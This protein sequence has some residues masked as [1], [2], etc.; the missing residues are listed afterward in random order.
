MAKIKE[1]IKSVYEGQKDF[2]IKYI[3]TFISIGII[4]LFNIFADFSKDHSLFY[5]IMIFMTVSCFTIES[6]FE[7]VWRKATLYIMSFILSIITGNFISSNISNTRIVLIIV[8]LY[9]A[10]FIISIYRIIENSE[11]TLSQFLSRF[12]RNMLIVSLI[13]V[14]LEIGLNLVLTI[15]VFLIFKPDNYDIFLRLQLIVLGLF[16]M[17][18][19][20]LSLLNVKEGMLKLL[21]IIICYVVL[22]IILIAE[23]VVYI[24]MFKIIVTCEIPKNQIFAIVTGMFIVAFPVWIMIQSFTEGNKYVKYCTKILPYSFIPL[25]ILQFYALAL[26]IGGNG[27]TPQRYFGVMLIVFEIVSIVLTLIKEQKYLKEVLLVVVGLIAISMI[28]PK[29]NAIE[30]SVANQVSRIKENYKENVEFDSLKEQQKDAVVSAYNFLKYHDYGKD[31]IPEY[32]DNEAIKKY[33]VDKNQY[34]EYYEE[35]FENY[36][37]YPQEEEEHNI[38]GY[39]T[40]KDICIFKYYNNETNQEIVGEGYN[41]EKNQE[42]DRIIEKLKDTFDKMITEKSI[43]QSFVEIDENTGIII[44]QCSIEHKDGLIRYIGLSGYLLKK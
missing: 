35:G 15:A 13:N 4:T 33:N 32:V 6:L 44:K 34:Q 10:L 3:G 8:G 40:I 28:M 21:K 29:T 11:L 17:P 5:F 26:R 22:P 30:F 27:V 7:D 43:E 18:A 42:E 31:K 38:E 1:S 39:K 20:I 36:Y 25:V 9:V 16:Y 12:F 14:I 23:V 24:Y 37:Y 19:L 2:I 41:F